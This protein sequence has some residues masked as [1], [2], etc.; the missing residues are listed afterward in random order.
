[1]SHIVEGQPASPSASIYYRWKSCPINHSHSCLGIFSLC[2]PKVVEL[3]E[4]S[5]I[6]QLLTKCDINQGIQNLTWQ[7]VSFLQKATFPFLC[8]CPQVPIV[9]SNCLNIQFLMFYEIKGFLTENWNHFRAKS[10]LCWCSWD[11][12]ARGAIA[13]IPKIVPV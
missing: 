13:I 6:C 7:N 1:M 11:T 8:T 9:Q 4:Y 2:I 5:I 10:W 12:I 3:V